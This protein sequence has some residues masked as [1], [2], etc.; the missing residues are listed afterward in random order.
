MVLD[1]F[2][3]GMAIG[4]WLAGFLA[5]VAFTA[6]IMAGFVAAV[7]LIYDAAGSVSIKTVKRGEKRERKDQ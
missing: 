7:M 4:A 1:F 2:T 3:R 6:L 5:V